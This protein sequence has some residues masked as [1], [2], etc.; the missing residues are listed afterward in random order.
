VIGDRQDEH[1]AQAKRPARRASRAAR[2]RIFGSRRRGS[3]LRSRALPDR[4]LARPSSSRARRPADVIAGQNQS[5]DRHS[6]PDV[7]VDGRLPRPSRKRR[8][9]QA[10][11]MI[12][13]MPAGRYASRPDQQGARV[14]ARRWI[15]PPR[16]SGRGSARTAAAAD[17]P[18]SAA[19]E[20]GPGIAHGGRWPRGQRKHFVPRIVARGVC[21]RVAGSGWRRQ[22]RDGYR[23]VVPLDLDRHTRLAD[24]DNQGHVLGN[25]TVADAGARSGSYTSRYRRCRCLAPRF[26]LG[27]GKLLLGTA[28]QSGWEK[29]VVVLPLQTPGRQG[30]GLARLVAFA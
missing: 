25:S 16:S 13:F 9:V 3:Q 30:F 23:A 20:G 26:D 11:V 27:T 7:D 24:T 28:D 1:L 17:T 8:G 12:D 18:P 6:G 10:S 15:A 22:A 5:L 29:R 4:P 2:R 21:R 14:D 19:T